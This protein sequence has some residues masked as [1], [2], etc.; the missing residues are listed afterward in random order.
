[1]EKLTLEDIAV[2][3]FKDRMTYAEIGSQY[4]MSKQAVNLRVQNQREYFN[5][6]GELFLIDAETQNEKMRIRRII[7]RISQEELAKKVGTVKSHICNIENGKI[8]E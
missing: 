3:Y 4:N 1:M 7:Y 6:L 8:K 2:K 5:T